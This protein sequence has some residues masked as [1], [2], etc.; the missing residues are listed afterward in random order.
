[1]K[2]LKQIKIILYVFGTFL[3]LAEATDEVS[4][5]IFKTLSE[6]ND[7]WLQA[8]SIPEAA[9]LLKHPP[10]SHHVK[11]QSL[12][13]VNISEILSQKNYSYS[14]NEATEGTVRSCSDDLVQIIYNVESEWALQMLDSDGKLTSGLLRGG[15]IWPGHYGECNSVYAP[16][17]EDGHGDFYGQY[18]VTSWSMNLGGK[19]SNLPLTVGLCIPDSCTGEDIQTIVKNVFHI[20]DRFPVL[21]QHSSL[22]S[23][24]SVTCKPKTKTLDVSSIIYLV[25]VFGFVLLTVIG[26]IVTI[27]DRRKR[28]KLTIAKQPRQ[29]NSQSFEA[30]TA[31]YVS[32]VSEINAVTDE[33]LPAGKTSERNEISKTS[34]RTK[35]EPTAIQISEKKESSTDTS[36]TSERTKSV[37]TALKISEE[38]ESASHIPEI[39]ETNL[40]VNK[41]ISSS[42]KASLMDN[43]E[44]G[45]VIHSKKSDDSVAKRILLCF[46]AICNGEKI[47]DTR[48]SEGQLLSIHGIRFLSLI[49]VI[50]GHT[51]ISS[52]SIIGN[53]L[54]ALKDMDTFPFQVLLQAPFS[55][56]SF[57]LLSGFL[58]TY[59]FLKEAAK[60]NG[61][62]NWLYFYVHRFWRLT[63]AYM[64]IV[65]FY[66][67]VFKYLGSGPF[68]EDKHC[69]NSHSDWWKYLLY[70]NNFIPINQMCVGWSWYLANDMQ[71]YLI[72]P[73]FL[74]P[75]WRWPKIGFGVLVSL[76]LA[77]WTTTGV[78]SYKYDL[79]PMFVGA[80]KTKDLE[81][82]AK[83]MWDSFDLIYDK[84][85]CR[86]APYLIGVF[87]GIALYKV[88]SRKNFLNWWQQVTGWALA[89]FFSLSVVFGL[90][91]V[92][93]S[94]LTSL[95]YN[96]LCRSSFSL[97][98]AWLIF[99]CETGHGGFV[100]KF[101]S[102]KF[103]IPLSRLT[104]CAY[105]VHPIL[106]HG[107]YMSYQTALYFTE[108]VTVTNFMG[109]MVMSYGIAFLFSLVFES[110]L[111]NLEK[112]IIKRNSQEK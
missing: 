104:Y 63:P 89:S 56:D 71:F 31:S 106:I 20:L 5:E 96:S 18:C 48:V 87:L 66:M 11:R 25:F 73:L 84:P 50:L 19:Y 37:P 78:L 29:G 98:L 109:F 61:K 8:I 108:L 82:Y 93:M 94:R 55:V 17:D 101:L 110:P 102:W 42:D 100:A 97:G 105:L 68:W 91:H 99:A 35:S 3:C 53:R 69:D 62:I 43:P 59:L 77:T 24:K 23:L 49:W 40:T 27:I 76:L 36:K 46:S 15:L 67:F 12:S 26:S 41:E 21:K 44:L 79:I 52:V 4:I 112:L 111:M 72:S 9:M 7:R 65:F 75:L 39:S 54:D 107:Y 90:Y 85:Y 10:Y 22:L 34:E 60:R 83:K 33:K 92:Q 103:W 58:L 57:F 38:T 1:M 30:N 95:F 88:N 74:Y 14:A 81:A 80:T 28:L 2:T 47:L 45:V 64:V 51:Y 70:I 13:H 6:L 32:E 86:I 16:K